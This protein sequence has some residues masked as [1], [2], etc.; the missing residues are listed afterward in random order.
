MSAA[1]GKQ[2]ANLIVDSDSDDGNNNVQS[3]LVRICL[4]LA[5][6]PEDQGRAFQYN[7]DE[8]AEYTEMRLNAI[9]QDVA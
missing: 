5:F 3:D 6:L 7:K 2:R 1:A 8:L 4:N 9:Q